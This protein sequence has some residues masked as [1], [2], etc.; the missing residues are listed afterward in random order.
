MPLDNYMADGGSYRRRRYA[1]LSAPAS[2]S[3]LKV[4]PQQPHYQGLRYNSLNGGIP[5]H[6]E[7]IDQRVL[8]GSTLPALLTL[9]CE[10]FGRLAPFSNWHIEVH[11]FR[12]EVQGVGDV[13][14]LPTPEGTHR[15]GVDFAMIIMIRRVNIVGGDTN[16]YDSDD[17]PI[18][19]FRLS[20]PLDLA[21]VNDE[22]VRHGVTPVAAEQAGRPGHRDVLVATFRHQARSDVVAHRD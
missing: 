22:R 14:A 9:G 2:T 15:D 3:N 7:P 10:L 19:T 8:N 20:Q 11:Q 16:L 5:R 4:E 13:G 1:T 12:I 21:I 6:Y 17:R 18:T